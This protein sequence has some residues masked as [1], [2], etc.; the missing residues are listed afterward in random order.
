MISVGL[1]TESEMQKWDSMINNS[2]NGTIFHRRKFL[3]YHHD[4]FLNNEMFLVFRKGNT[5]IALMSLVVDG[6]SRS[7]KSPY[8]GSY[9]GVIFLVKPDYGVSADV[10]EA[11]VGWLRSNE[12]LSVTITAPLNIC[13][14]F[15]QDVFHFCLLK[16]GFTTVN[17]DISS[18][19]N[20]SGKHNILESVSGRARNMYRKAERSGVTVKNHVSLDEF[21]PILMLGFSKHGVQP[22]HSYKDLSYLTLEMP[23]SISF[24]VAQLEG[25]IIAGLCE[26]VINAKVNSSFYFCQDQ[27][28]QQYQGLS[29]LVVDALERAKV[30][31]DYYDF[32]TSTVQMNVRE[33]VFKFK[34]SFSADGC[35]R[36]TLCWSAHL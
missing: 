2:V 18:F 26:F 5:P 35:F 33:N 32:G 29:M 14:D 36:E 1:A 10:A 27:N 23:E 6:E 21:W 11:L 16:N 13:S 17:R 19:F 30:D 15:S 8:G 24:H 20:F 3:A 7:L 25:I 4:R 31:F 34:E 12:F 28:H 9:G 22:T